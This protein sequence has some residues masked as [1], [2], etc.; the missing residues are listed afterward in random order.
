VQ[1]GG[2]VTDNLDRRLFATYASVYYTPHVL[3]A[4]FAFNPAHPIMRFPGDFRY[5]VPDH[6]DV[7]MY[8]RF[9]AV[10][11]EVDSPEVYGLHPNADLTFRVKEANAMLSTLSET[12]PK[13]AGGGGG[14]SLDDVV[15]DK[16][17]EL[18]G[19]LPPAYVEDEYRARIKRLG[20]LG[21]PLNIFL[22]QEIQRFQAVLSRVRAMLVSMQQAIRGEVV[23]TSELLQA[24][25]DI[26]DAR[27]PRSWLYTPGGDEF[28]WL[29]PTL[30]MWFTSL[31]ERDDQ[32]RTWLNNTRPTSYWIAGFSNPQ[33]FLTAMKQEV[34]RLHRAQH[35]PLDE[36]E[37]YSEVTDV[38]RADAVK[39]APKEGVYVHGLYVEGARWEKTSGSLAESEP[40][41]LFAAMPVVYVTAFAKALLKERRDALGPCYDAPLYRYPAR[42]E[43]Y[44]VLSLALPAGAASPDHWILRGVCLL[45]LTM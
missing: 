20:G 19:K 10:F 3:D 45:C 32:L 8:R 28:S 18:L 42:T 30:G 25:T 7:D 40:K 1:Y 17:T 6:A 39:T 35:W 31:L 15:M 33:G 38:E 29:I 44:R 24:M 4:S 11:P 37:Y 16:A 27:V 14:R 21:E 23:M 9:A 34:T 13:Q 41:K 22:F 12:Q 43:R 36:V 26:F 2:K 5:D